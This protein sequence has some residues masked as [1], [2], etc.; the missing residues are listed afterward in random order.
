[1]TGQLYPHMMSR[2]QN[3]DGRALFFLN[4]VRNDGFGLM[5]MVIAI[6]VLAVISA[7]TI[8]VIYQKYDARMIEKTAL[9][10]HHIQ[11]AAKNYRKDILAWPTSIAAIQ[12]AGYLPSGWTPAN[13]W[14]NNYNISNNGTTFTVSVV[15][16][17]KYEN[18][19]TIFLPTVTVDTVSHTASSTIPIPGQEASLLTLVRIDGSNTMT[20]DL[21]IQ[22][23]TPAVRLWDTAS[24][25][26]TYMKNT[27][28]TFS[29]QSNTLASLVSV[30][31]AGNTG[32]GG[33][34]TT[35]KLEVYGTIGAQNNNIVNVANP[36]NPQ[37]VA[38]KAY[39]D[40]QAGGGGTANV[41]TAYI[42]GGTNATL[43]CSAGKTITSATAVTAA[44][45]NCTGCNLF[46]DMGA[47][48][49]YFY[50]GPNVNALNT[51]TMEIVSCRGAASCQLYAS[52]PSY[53]GIVC[54]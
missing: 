48:Y 6:S 52:W 35:N 37:D 3:K 34:T 7:A 38:T 5:E 2:R 45:A 54:N 13:L 16:P 4:I 33:A 26:S 18:A 12:A 40:A 14:G 1:M 8:P 39:V 53:L 10:I 30:S 22:K 41:V 42:N 47:G 31:Q 28:G 32:I 9:E 46:W 11:E 27:N 43:N 19:L 36:V 24:S 49:N 17:Q 29:I 25:N 23:I 15:M 51:A 50:T 20:G 21:T 44:P